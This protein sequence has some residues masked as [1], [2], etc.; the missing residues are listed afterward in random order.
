VDSLIA[1]E[2]PDHS[3][4]LSG[5]KVLFL[6][7][8][9]LRKDIASDLDTV[10]LQNNAVRSPTRDCPTLIK[11]LEFLSI[12]LFQL[13]EK[14]AKSFS[15]E[16]VSSLKKEEF[17]D[18]LNAACLIDRYDIVDSLIA[19]ENPDHSMDLS[20]GKWTSLLHLF[21]HSNS[22]SSMKRLLTKSGV[23]VNI[24]DS[25]GNTPLMVAV[26]V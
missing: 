22:L 15:V 12:H 9:F 3:M 16:N 8:L 2:N 1:T 21:L 6:C 13:Y 23:D 20:G 19:T 24:K 18:L 25:D 26:G 7:T 11:Q 5:G 4:D 14:D 10:Y 17:S